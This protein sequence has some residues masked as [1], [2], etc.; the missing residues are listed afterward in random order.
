MRLTPD[1]LIFLRTHI[2]CSGYKTGTSCKHLTPWPQDQL[3]VGMPVDCSN[4]GTILPVG[5]AREDKVGVAGED[6][7]GGCGR[8]QG[9]CGRLNCSTLHIV[10]SHHSLEVVHCVL[11]LWFRL[12]FVSAVRL[13]AFITR[14]ATLIK[15]LHGDYWRLRETK[16]D[17]YWRILEITGDYWRL[18]EITG[19]YWRLLEITGDY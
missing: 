16:G 15:R 12:H 9:G 8:G 10:Q 13:T 1:L 17:Y 11:C 18:L 19:D 2:H 5:V 4:D 6:V 7:Q 14:A 3:A